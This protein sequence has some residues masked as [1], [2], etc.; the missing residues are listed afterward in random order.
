MD[1]LLIRAKNGDKSAEDEIFQFLL[2]RFSLF[3]AQKIRDKQTAQDIAQEACIAVLE[4][5]KSETFT[6][7]FEV[8]A[9]GVLHTMIKNHFFRRSNEQKLISKRSTNDE[10]GRFTAASPDPDLERQLNNCLKKIL[11]INQRYARVLNL[12]YQG[13]NTEEIC[14]RLKIDRNNL[15]VTL[16]RARLMLKNCLEK[17]EL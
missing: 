14:Q 11:S 12:V 1:H 17:G 16:Y 4:K 7:S 2:V 8:W 9:W 6:H 3:A 13:Y 5:Y 10:S 15:Y